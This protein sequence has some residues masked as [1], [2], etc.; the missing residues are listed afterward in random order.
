VR[1]PEGIVFSKPL[2]G[3]VIRFLAW[4]TDFAVIVALLG[5]LRYAISLLGLFSLDF[6]AAFSALAYFVISIGYGIFCE[7]HWRG[8][9]LGK[10]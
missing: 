7:W 2:A 1:T 8:Q 9:T 4:F 10:R 5:L 6:A 3:P